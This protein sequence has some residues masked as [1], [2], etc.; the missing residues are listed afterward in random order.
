MSAHRIKNAVTHSSNAWAGRTS[1]IIL[2]SITEKLFRQT[3]KRVA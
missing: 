2:T 1:C 3:I